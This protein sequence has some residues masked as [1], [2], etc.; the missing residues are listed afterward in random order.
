MTVKL[1]DIER[2]ATAIRD[3][4]MRTPLI[5]SRR[6]SERTGAEI[7]LKL[8][9]FQATGSFKDRGALNKL[10]S[11]GEDDRSRGVMATSAGNH[12]QGV[13]FHA[14]IVAGAGALIV[15]GHIERQER[16]VNVVT[17]RMEAL[18]VGVDIP[19]RTHS[20]R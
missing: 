13:A 3:G 1:D 17:E 8:E 6:L 20:F 10:L 15:H 11:L 18:P 14:K 19:E 5:P 12:A 16:A 7:S 9:I 2:A 4:V